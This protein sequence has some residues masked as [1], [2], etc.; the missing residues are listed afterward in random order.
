MFIGRGEWVENIFIRWKIVKSIFF[1]V[2]TNKEKNVNGGVNKS[3]EIL[4]LVNNG[5]KI[6][7]INGVN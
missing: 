3:D 1:G 2:K 5:N 6:L 7:S 4:L